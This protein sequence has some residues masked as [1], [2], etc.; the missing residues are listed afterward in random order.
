[1]QKLTLPLKY[2][3]LTGIQISIHTGKEI[4]LD[5]SLIQHNKVKVYG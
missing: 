2:Y 1:M 4:L 3:G 5:W